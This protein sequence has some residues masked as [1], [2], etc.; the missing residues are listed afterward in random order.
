MRNR[1]L[2]A[3]SWLLA[4]IAAT[5]VAA[6][7]LMSAYTLTG[8]QVV[9]RDLGRF[10][11]T[12]NLSRVTSLEPQ[13]AGLV[14]TIEAAALAGGASEAMVL[15]ISVDDIRP[16]QANPPR[17]WYFETDW[18]RAPFPGR[19]VLLAGRWP[20]RP[21]EVTVARTRR[22]ALASPGDVLP[23]L[24]GHEQF[25]V[26]G[27]VDDRYGDYHEILAAPGTFGTIGEAALQ[28]FP[29]VSAVPVLY[30]EGGERQRVIDSV[31]AELAQELELPT[32]EVAHTLA[33]VIQDPAQVRSA[34][35]RS[36]VER[37]PGSYTVPS[38]LLPALASLAVFVLGQRRLRRS[39]RLLVA[40]GLSPARAALAL[41][42]AVSG[43]ILVALVAGLALGLGIGLAGRLVIEEFELRAQ[44]LSPFPSLIDPVARLAVGAVAAC[45]A[46]TALAWLALGEQPP[47]QDPAAHQGQPETSRRRRHLANVRHGL[48]V[49]VACVSIVLVS[50]L[51][52]VE[53]AMVLA[54]TVAATVLL[55]VP[56]ALEWVLPLFPRQDPRLRLAR[57]HLEHE[58]ARGAVTVTV[59]AAVLGLSLG[60]LGLIETLIATNEQQRIPPVAPGQLLVSGGPS[61]G[62]PAV[63]HDR[64][65]GYDPPV[66]L[67]YLGEQGILVMMRHDLGI[68]LVLD[69]VDDVGRLLGRSLTAEEAALLAGGGML[70]WD[71][72]ESGERTLVY[73][74]REV[75]LRALAVRIYPGWRH[76]HNGVMLAATA[77][78]LGLPVSDGGLLF[79][80]IPDTEAQAARQAVLDAGLDPSQV[81]IYERREL[82][83][84]QALFAGAAG[85][86]LVVLLGSIALS[87]AQVATMR[88][89][90]GSLIA[91]GLSPGWARQ[92]V[93][94][95]NAFLLAVSTILALVMAIPTVVIT[96]WRMPDFVFSLPW[97]A[98]G[99]AI[100]ACYLAVLL[101]TVLSCRRLRAS[102]RSAL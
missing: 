39:G 70:A 41:G 31:S 65:G 82:I 85:L 62:I 16:A 28:A 53:E 20:E 24:A 30:W 25:Q 71:G 69:T 11:F 48:A 2:A 23:V 29:R 101:A 50:R 94:A 54:G 78:R 21:G 44:E 8:E 102:D 95:Q 68:I 59:L 93:M 72:E 22:G 87:R 34:A 33:E 80:G 46:G 86:M 83:V 66:H 45:V 38:L 57:R 37:L 84:P 61:A 63:V 64:L 88:R 92:V 49:L 42:V 97:P 100:A 73:D 52:R 77:E 40:L 91:V 75:R 4:A 47:I 36:W 60:Y 79:T 19:Y 99:M 17:T 13:D 58:R 5:V 26:V 55:L 76:S 10:E 9:E 1:S 35:P 96:A 81:R 90:L 98:M 14:R 56:E 43:W 6:Y 15:L 7:I 74:E 12:A 27:L 51:D 18:S 67:R 89:Y 3:S 32:G